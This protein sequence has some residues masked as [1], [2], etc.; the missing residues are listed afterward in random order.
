MCIIKKDKIVFVLHFHYERITKMKNMKN[1]IIA[2]SVLTAFATAAFSGCADESSSSLTSEEKDGLIKNKLT[3]SYDSD[4]TSSDD[5]DAADPT[6]AANSSSSDE[7]QNIDNSN[8]ESATQYVDVTDSN[9]AKVTTQVAVTDAAG[10]QVTDSAGKTV[11]TVVNVTKAVTASKSNNSNKT[12]TT[13]SSGSSNSNYSA[14]MVN[15]NA[16]WLDISKEKDFTFDGDFIE[17]EMKINENTPAGKYP[18][19][20]TN[21][22]FSNFAAT[23][24]IYPATVNGYIYVSQDPEQQDTTDNGKFTVIAQ[25]VSGKPGD[26]VHL[27]FKMLNNPG[28]CAMNFNFE[29]DKNAV[30]IQN[31]YAAGDFVN[32]SHN[33]EF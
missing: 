33:A 20:I 1:K 7:L 11:T 17:V 29:Y 6:G 12:Q 22:Q 23:G 14:N 28:L 2:L 21:P 27:K 13:T 15:F 5:L 10:K 16:Y 30:T 19:N 4:S 9:G 24:A 32:I 18:I 25:N 3:F 31:A 26:T 8:S